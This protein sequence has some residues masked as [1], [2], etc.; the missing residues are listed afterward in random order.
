[1]AS[2]RDILLDLLHSASEAGLATHSAALPGYPFASS[3]AFATDEHHRPVLLISRLAEHTQNLAA[4]PRAS[5]VVARSLGEGEIARASLMG[6]LAPMEADARLTARYL[7]FQP[8]AERFLQLG[9]FCF[10]RFEPRRIRIVGGFGQ[11]GWLEAADLLK[12]PSLDL[13][14]EARLMEA[15]A[16]RL[17][18]ET[19]LLGLD[20]YGADIL[21]DG[22]RRRHTVVAGPVLGD[23]LLAALSRELAP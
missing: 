20:P 4:D 2:R 22:T 5:L 1:M 9:D 12:A 7:R 19:I 13:D 3:V 15:A 8:A 17:P 18:A 23:A 16:P 10:H 6:E 21:V 14:E 11:A